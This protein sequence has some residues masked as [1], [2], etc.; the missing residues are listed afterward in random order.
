V[1]AETFARILRDLGKFR[2]KGAGF[3]AWLFRIASNLAIDRMREASKEMVDEKAVAARETAATDS[4][5]SEVL[6]ME[7]AADLSVKLDSLVP[8]QREVLLLR[9]AADLDTAE[10]ARVMEKKTNAIRQLQFRA[11]QKIR[12][13]MSEEVA[14]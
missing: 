14:L 9:F 12:E 3:E 11:L 1:A 2:W 7:V 8:E 5:E 10:V 13:N 6:R 4:P